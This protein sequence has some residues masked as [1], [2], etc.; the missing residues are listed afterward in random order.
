MERKA[1][2]LLYSCLTQNFANNKLMWEILRI[3]KNLK[4]GR[5][6]FIIFRGIG[7]RIDKSHPWKTLIISSKKE[8][9]MVYQEKL[10]QEKVDCWESSL[11]KFP[12]TRAIFRI[13]GVWLMSSR[14]PSYFPTLFATTSLSESSFS[15]TSTM[16]LSPNRAWSLIL[17][18][19]STVIKPSL[20]RRV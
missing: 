19:S 16:K 7:R 6:I 3:Q 14:N 4:K 12:I 9:F 18:F 1:T 2:V 8:S 15:R 17:R 5:F 11:D 20:E 13:M 10:V